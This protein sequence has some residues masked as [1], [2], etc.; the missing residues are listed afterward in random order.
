ML[1]ASYLS[2]WVYSHMTPILWLK[3]ESQVL[4]G[5]EL[6][7]LMFAAC[8]YNHFAIETLIT[9]QKQQQQEQYDDDD[10]EFFLR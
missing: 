6:I 10:D 2:S 9:Q 8:S 4:A 5:S 7:T 1:K 3:G